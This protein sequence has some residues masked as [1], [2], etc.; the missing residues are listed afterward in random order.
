MTGGRLPSPVDPGLYLGTVT[1][2]T[3]SQVQVNFPNATARPERRGLSRGAVGDFVF[4]DCE[5]VKLLGSVRQFRR[6]RSGDCGLLRDPRLPHQH[7]N[8]FPRTGM[9]LPDQRHLPG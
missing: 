9:P 2:V 6:P 4:I 1:E 3:A 5:R 7:P 8:Q